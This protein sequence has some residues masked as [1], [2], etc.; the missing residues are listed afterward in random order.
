V[1][2]DGGAIPRLAMTGVRKAFGATQ[3]LSGVDLQVAAGEVHAL[4]GE[5]GAGKSTLMKVLSGA[6]AP[7]AGT[8][9]LDG[10]PFRPGDPLAARRAGVA[11]VYQELAIAPHLSVAENVLLGH[12][13]ARC[14]VV[15][16]HERDRVAHAAMALLGRGDLPLHRPAGQLSLAERQLVEIA[17]AIATS[18]RVLVLDEPTSSLTRGDAEHLLTVVRRLAARGVAVVYISHYLEEVLRGC[19]RY[20]VLRDGATVASGAV[21]DAT[22]PGLIRHMVGR[23]VDEAYPRVPHAIGEPVLAVRDLAGMAKPAAA[24]FVLRRGEIL[25]VFGLV[26]AGRTETLRALFGLDP[27]RGG[28]VRFAGGDGRRSPAGWLR[29]GLGLVSENR[30]EEGLLLDL[31]IA[32]NLT[33]TRLGPYVRV[34]LLSGRRQRAAT[35]DWMERLGVRAAGPGQAVGQLSGGN[36][37]KVAIGRL[38]HHGCQVLLL[39]EP[40]RGVDIGAKA[41]IYRLIGELAARGTAIVLVSSYLPELLGVCDSVAAMCRGVL[42]E[43]RPAAEW[44]EEALLAAAIGQ[45]AA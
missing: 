30:K 1:S 10:A 43:A 4:I 28:A 41:A 42:G 25:G 11:I 27:R 40:T 8:I 18:P 6:H 15:R 34:G 38:L 22:I 21:A 23:A 32:D 12:L 36:Q 19:D 13:P 26:G 14:G 37:Q 7:D 31:P 5:N 24:S 33:L 35:A 44:S 39:D 2:G 20:T 16:G 45:E 3:A 29:A 17:R 9:A